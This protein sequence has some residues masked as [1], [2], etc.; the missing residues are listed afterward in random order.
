MGYVAFLS[1]NWRRWGHDGKNGQTF[2]RADQAEKETIGKR[3]SI[4]HVG[5]ERRTCKSRRRRRALWRLSR[6]RLKRRHWGNERPKPLWVYHGDGGFP[7]G[8][9]FTERHLHSVSWMKSQ[10][11][12]WQNTHNLVIL[13]ISWKKNR[14]HGV[15]PFAPSQSG[16]RGAV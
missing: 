8:Y 14:C 9:A 6:W 2:R 10:S 12:S 4:L 5:T 7:W 15:C 16:G 1:L 11:E 13:H 3:A